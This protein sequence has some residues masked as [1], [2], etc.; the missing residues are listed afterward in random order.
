MRTE[1][2]VELVV[3]A[4][5]ILHDLRAVLSQQIMFLGILELRSAVLVGAL[6]GGVAVVVLLLLGL[7]EFVRVE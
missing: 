1:D 7:L 5:E 4:G 6:R 3:T 2:G